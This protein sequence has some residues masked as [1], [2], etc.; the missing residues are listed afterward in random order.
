M[1][2]Q[3]SMAQAPPSTKQNVHNASTGNSVA[4]NLLHTFAD[5]PQALSQ[6]RQQAEALL[7]VLGSDSL[8][9]DP[10]INATAEAQK[11]LLNEATLATLANLL[12]QL[13]QS[14]Q[15]PP[16]VTAAQG[17]SIANA[18]APLG[19]GD[20]ILEFRVSLAIPATCLSAVSIT[21][22]ARSCPASIHLPHPNLLHACLS[23]SEC[24]LSRATTRTHARTWALMTLSESQVP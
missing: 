23:R 5:F 6:L 2:A 9:A 10:A 14:S 16:N 24:K 15:I 12:K 7:T 21:P 17:P 8:G 18:F 20:N 19:S 22:G 4:D 13:Q 3:L 1:Q 11:Q